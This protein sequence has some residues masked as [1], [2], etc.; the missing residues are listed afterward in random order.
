MPSSTTVCDDTIMRLFATTL[1]LLA[2]CAT[3]PS[4]AQPATEKPHLVRC[5]SVM[6]YYLPGEYYF[7][8]GG[9]RQFGGDPEGA[10][11]YFERAAAW[12]HKKAQYVLGLMHFQGD[13]TPADRALGLA[14]LT[15]AAERNNR[16]ID[17]ALAFA[18]RHSSKSEQERAERLLTSMR[19]TYADT[20][21][22]ERAATRYE[23][24]TRTL[25]RTAIFDPLA[26]IYISG[27]GIS[28]GGNMLRQLDQRA[29]AYFEDT[30]GTVTIGE[31]DVVRDDDASSESITPDAGADEP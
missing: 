30:S 4:D 27:F 24:E 15:L 6:E 9:H 22:V 11:G 5:P 10:L 1:A 28:S 21:T 17:A 26:E 13:G 20:V 2:L 19:P 18:R 14:W 7:C 29:A 8:R 31:L 16:D 23:R 25:R 3:A 12:G